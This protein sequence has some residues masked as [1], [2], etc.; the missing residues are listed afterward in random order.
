MTGGITFSEATNGIWRI[1][2]L[3]FGQSPDRLI[4]WAC[5]DP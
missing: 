2:Y 3:H 5:T 4:L 1:F